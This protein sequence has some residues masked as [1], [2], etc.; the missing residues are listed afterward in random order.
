[1]TGPSARIILDS[2]HPEGTSR[3]TTFEVVFHRFVLAEFNTHRVF[4][5]N[6]A[7]S[8]AIPVA[9]QIDRVLTNTALPLAWPRE[10]KGMQG[11]EELDAARREEAEDIWREAA[12]AAVAYAEELVKLGVHKSVVNRLLEPFMWHTVVVTATEWDNFWGLRC[13]KL[14]QPELRAAAELMR[15]AYSASTPRQLAYGDW[16]LPLVDGVDRADIAD[17]YGV[18][19]K[20][21]EVAKQISAARC[22]RVSYLTHDGKRDWDADLKLAERL[23]NPGDGPPHASPFEHVCTPAKADEERFIRGNLR[24]WRQYRHFIEGHHWREAA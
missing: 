20:G 4:S 19:Y 21:V 18:G 1:M 16:H 14:A 10:Q 17:R 5:R 22:A 3:V 15:E 23:I 9:K 11:G 2:L 13:N 12:G 24:G 8:R 7:S 6:S